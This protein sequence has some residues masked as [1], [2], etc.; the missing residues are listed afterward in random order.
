MLIL[1]HE[2]L[3]IQDGSAFRPFF[4]PDIHASACSAGA[5]SSLVEDFTRVH[6][7]GHSVSLRVLFRHQVLAA[8]KAH[9]F[10]II[11]QAL[12]DYSV[13]SHT[14]ISTDSLSFAEDGLRDSIHDGISDAHEKLQYGGGRMVHVFSDNVLF[15]YSGVHQGALP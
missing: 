4:L 10:K 7:R 1:H 6:L 5:G 8:T 11:W 12:G 15:A 13:V 14:H 9:P 3:R 2:I